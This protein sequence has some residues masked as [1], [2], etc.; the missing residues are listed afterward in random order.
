MPFDIVI[1]ITPFGNYAS[2]FN[3][4]LIIKKKKKTKKKNVGCLH[5]LIIFL[6][7]SRGENNYIVLKFILLEK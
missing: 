5:L 6:I 2:L 3:S 4:F 7:K 1:W